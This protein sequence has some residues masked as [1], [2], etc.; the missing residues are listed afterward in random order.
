MSRLLRTLLIAGAA[1]VL[2][3]FFVY[4]GFPYDRL[5]DYAAD[6]IES[7]TGVRV[8]LSQLDSKL[9]LQGPGLIAHNVVA[10]TQAGETW[11]LDVV[12]ARPAWS[13]SW[14]QGRPALY[15]DVAAPFG[16]VRGVTKLGQPF[17]FD[18]E[19]E[20][21]DL[22]GLPLEALLAGVELDGRADLVAD[23][24]M[25][26]EG[27]VGPLQLTAREGSI[28]HPD[29]PVAIPYEEIV[30]DLEFGGAQRVAIATLDI[31]SPMGTGSIQGTVGNS[32]N[33]ANAPLD[34]R[35][36]VTADESMR[37]AFAATGAQFDGDGN[38]SVQVTGT[39]SR[40]QVD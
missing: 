14:L 3:S 19:A 17:A 13:L 5:A 38:L 39:A 37:G 32:E 7:A 34:L 30:G 18:G 11:N 9:F 36:D 21:V 20:G 1:I 24:T 31:A 23:V 8:T 27:P 4:L 29:F 16:S 2:T 33:P 6:E 40:P 28:A 26:P 25:Q 15:L 12:A 35:I 10:R 22:S